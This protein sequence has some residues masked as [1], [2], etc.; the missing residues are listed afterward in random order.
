[1]IAALLGLAII[2]LLVVLCYC[3]MKGKKEQTRCQRVPVNGSQ[4]YTR[5]DTERLVY[6]TTTKPI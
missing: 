5:E 6:N 3:F 1:V 2:I 4:V